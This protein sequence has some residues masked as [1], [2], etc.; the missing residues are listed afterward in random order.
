MDVPR[1]DP[2]EARVMSS[3]LMTLDRRQCEVIKVAE[4]AAKAA[5]ALMEETGG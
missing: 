3:I 1:P 2:P 5:L 4:A